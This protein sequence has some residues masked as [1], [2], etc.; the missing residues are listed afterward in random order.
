MTAKI[1]SLRDARTDQA[2]QRWYKLHRKIW[3]YAID[4]GF[5]FGDVSAFGMFTMS[6]HPGDNRVIRPV[7]HKWW[8]APFGKVR[9]IDKRNRNRPLS[10]HILLTNFRSALR[11]TLA[12]VDA[13]L[14]QIRKGK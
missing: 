10:R 13:E 3:E 11:R 7:C 8:A 1:V 5:A 2:E 12:E 14:A 9:V 4:E 6:M